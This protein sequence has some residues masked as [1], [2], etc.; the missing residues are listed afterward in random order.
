MVV[1]FYQVV[2]DEGEVGNVVEQYQFVYGIVNDYLGIG[3]GDFVCVVQSKVYFSFLYYF[4]GVREVF[5][6][7]GNKDQQQVWESFQQFFMCLEDDLFFIVV[8]VGGN[9]DFVVWCLLLMQCYCLGCQFWCDGDIEFQVVG[10]C[11]LVVFQFQGEE[12]V[13]IFFILC[14]DKCNVV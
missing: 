3:G 2:V 9:L 13:I 10:D 1:V 12:V 7:V 5:W 6:M 11:Q 4:M 14:G 8:G